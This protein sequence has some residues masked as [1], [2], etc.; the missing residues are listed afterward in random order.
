[1]VAA[2]RHDHGP[3]SPWPP[4]LLQTIPCEWWFSVR[5]GRLN[6]IYQF[7]PQSSFWRDKELGF[8][9]MRKI[10]SRFSW[11]TVSKMDDGKVWSCRPRPWS[12]IIDDTYTLSILARIALTKNDVPWVYVWMRQHATLAATTAAS[13]RFYFF[14]EDNKAPVN[15]PPNCWFFFNGR[16]HCQVKA[17]F[18]FLARSFIIIIFY[19]NSF[20]SNNIRPQTHR[21]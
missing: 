5:R 4:S 8:I 19:M 10:R 11:W 3:T 21:C 7:F 14:A 6:L 13:L 15:K 18:S 17:Y 20:R 12:G 9:R 1:M 2:P 16:S